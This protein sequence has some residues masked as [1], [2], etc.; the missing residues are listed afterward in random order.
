MAAGTFATAINCM[1][2]RVIL[3]VTEWMKNQFKVDYVDMITEAGPDKTLSQGAP[4]QIQS[5]KER[6]LISVEK[7]NSK[8]IAIIGHHDCAGNPVSKDKHIQQLKDCCDILMSWDLN[9]QIIGVWLNE[10]WGI[11]T[12]YPKTDKV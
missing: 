7:H 2:G 1:D 5:I 6:V 3:P 9:A 11:E 4:A 8:V 10:Q 12:V